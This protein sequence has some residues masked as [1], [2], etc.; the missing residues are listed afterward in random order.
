MT[1]L[2]VEDSGVHSDHSGAA[3]TAATDMP[4]AHTCSPLQ[5]S[6]A[7]GPLTAATPTTPTTPTTPKTAH[8]H[9][10]GQGKAQRPQRMQRTVASRPALLGN[11]LFLGEAWEPIIAV[12]E[13]HPARHVL[14]IVHHF[15]KSLKSK[16][17]AIGHYHSTCHRLTPKLTIVKPSCHFSLALPAPLSG[18]CPSCICLPAV[19]QPLQ[20]CPLFHLPPSTFRLVLSSQSPHHNHLQPQITNQ[21]QPQ[22]PPPPPPPP[23]SASA[24]APPPP[25]LPP[26]RNISP[27]PM[28]IPFVDARPARRYSSTRPRLA[29]PWPALFAA[30]LY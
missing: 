8:N 18:P 11:A 26:P 14:T 28:A 23:P 27:P 24:S 25:P 5:P 13:N 4:G 1:T 3:C 12:Q 20:G 19:V 7:C 30:S 17:R 21:E 29:N 9:P 10:Y 6:G 2:T 22:Q 16:A 15:Q